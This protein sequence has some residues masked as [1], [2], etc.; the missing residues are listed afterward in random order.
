MTTAKHEPEFSLRHALATL[1]YRAAKAV[2]DAPESFAEFRPADGSRSAG[3][4]LAHMGDLMDWALS[5]ARGKEQW[6][7][8]TP[9]PWSEGSV[10]FFA[11]VTALDE[12]LASDAGLRVPAEK[13]FQGAIADALTHVGQIAML[14]RLAGSRIRAENYSV[15]Q[16]RA[17]STG[18]DQI[19][20]VR[21]F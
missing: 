21:E 17:G 16:I 18:P 1:A 12:Y 3:E 10:R 6:Q 4:I 20:P 2:R 14:R 11:A 7:E 9:R 8:A 19:P 15:A 13:L 5:Q